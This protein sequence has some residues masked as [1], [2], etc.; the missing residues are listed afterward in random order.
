MYKIKIAALILSVFS[1]LSQAGTVISCIDKSSASSQYDYGDAPSSYGSACHDTDRWQKLGNTWDT[2][3][4][5][6]SEGSDNATDDGVKWKTSSDGG[7][8]WSSWSSNGALKQGD[9]VK[10]K[11][12]V[13]RSNDGNH[14]Y[15]ELK[16]WID[17]NQDFNWSNTDEV[18]KM[19]RWY[20]NETK[21]GELDTSS[22]NFNNDLGTYNSNITF[23]KFYRTMTI[24]LDAVLGD[25]WMR[26]RVVCE[27]S[28]SQYSA[29][30]VLDAT[31]Y[32]HQGEVE[33]Y[34]LTIVAKTA[35]VPEPSTLFIFALGLFALGVK[36]KKFV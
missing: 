26:V 36:R 30:Q 31:G 28:I 13:N 22:S 35:S 11:F 33:D 34:K 25:T 3:S 6:N 9:K 10:F 32:Q 21:K 18:I 12:S 19:K 24:P 1:G 29:N 2:D 16:S 7:N 4:A 15:D 23:A 14:Q 27:N 20:K 17:W 5:I 8:T